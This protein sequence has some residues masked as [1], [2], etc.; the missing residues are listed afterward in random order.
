MIPNPKT[1]VVIRLGA[2]EAAAARIAGRRF[3]HFCFLLSSSRSLADVAA[4]DRRR[5]HADAD[6]AGSQDDT[7]LSHFAALPN[8]VAASTIPDLGNLPVRS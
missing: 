8:S 6:K 4:G 1:P 7:V 2:H 5:D 3:G